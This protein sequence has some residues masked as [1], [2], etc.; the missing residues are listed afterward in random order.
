MA[1]RMSR[2]AARPR[3]PDRRNDARRNSEEHQNDEGHDGQGES[4]EPL[5]V[6][7][8]DDGI[9]EQHADN[10]ALHCAEQCGDH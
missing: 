3:G 2:R 7:R 9:A 10:D 5:I 4:S 8:D 6:Q 1:R